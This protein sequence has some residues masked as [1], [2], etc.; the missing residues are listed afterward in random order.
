MSKLIVGLLVVGLIGLSYLVVSPAPANVRPAAM[1]DHEA[2]EKCMKELKG[3]MR[4]MRKSLGD[5]AQKGEN[6]AQILVMQ[7]ALIEA[8]SLV[9]GVAAKSEKKDE[10]ILKY[11]GMM[12]DCLAA[13]IKMERAVLDGK[14]DEA[15]AAMRELQELQDSGH[16]SF[17]VEDD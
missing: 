16:A 3:A 5:E 6:L 2:L 14:G 1:D 9:P 4:R 15:K 10:M 12:L 17:K 7:K 8:K 11:R 13:T